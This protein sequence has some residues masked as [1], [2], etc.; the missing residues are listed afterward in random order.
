MWAKAVW[1][2][3]LGMDIEGN[4]VSHDKTEKPKAK[5]PLPAHVLAATKAAKGGTG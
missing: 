1:L 3:Q 4:P 5:T 2:P